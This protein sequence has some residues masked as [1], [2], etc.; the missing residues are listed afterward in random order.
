MGA[1]RDDL[2]VQIGALAQERLA[3]A[4]DRYVE[5]WRSG[6]AILEPGDRANPTV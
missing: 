3:I 5:T 1:E 6:T 2:D 4:P